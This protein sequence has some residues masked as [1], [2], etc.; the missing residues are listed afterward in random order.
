MKVTFY[1]LTPSP[2]VLRPARPQRDWMDETPARHAYKCLPLTIANGHG[3]DIAAPCAFDVSWNG[4]PLA[5]DL[6]VRAA[7]DFPWF[8]HFAMSH[9]ANGV[10]TMHVGYL[11]RTE[12]GWHLVAGGPF[13]QPKDG[14]AP[15]TGVIESDWLPYPFTMNWRMTRAGTVRFDRGETICTVFPIKAHALSR[16]DVE[17]RDIA[18]DPE[19]KQQM[20]AWANS[21][22]E[23]LKTY[24]T[25]DPASLKEAWQRF[26]FK[27]EYASGA[28]AEREHASKLRVAT[29]VDRRARKR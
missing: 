1:A 28:A 7:E 21:R 12:P 19:L 14:I 10:V 26:Y 9:F 22:S 23:F 29:P 20:D 13:N 15:L 5:A 25:G 4:G 8:D 27:G 16:T 17:I 3:W 2:P 6:T 18:D 24:N 11:I